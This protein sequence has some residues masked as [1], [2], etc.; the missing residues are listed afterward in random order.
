MLGSE[1]NFQRHF[2]AIVLVPLQP[3]QIIVDVCQLQAILVSN[4][5]RRRIDRTPKAMRLISLL[6]H[7]KLKRF[8]L[9]EELQR[10]TLCDSES[11]LP[12]FG[13]PPRTVFVTGADERAK[14]TRSDAEYE[15]GK[16]TFLALQRGLEVPFL[17]AERSQSVE[18]QTEKRSHKHWIQRQM[19]LWVK[20]D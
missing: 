1:T 3:L 14:R 20:S 18:R 19:T 17:N 10:E 2:R 8:S 11:S 6:R 12:M 15:K 13:V 5:A 7:V 9:S 4:T 16:K